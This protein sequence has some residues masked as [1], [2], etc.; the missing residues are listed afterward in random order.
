MSPSEPCEATDD[1]DDEDCGSGDQL[2]SDDDLDDSVDERRRL[3]VVCPKCVLLRNANPERIEYPR[4]RP[5]SSSSAS[6][7]SG[8]ARRRKPICSKWHNLGSWERV[9]TGDYRPTLRGLT[10]DGSCS[11][12]GGTSVPLSAG[13][14][15]LSATGLYFGGNALPDHE[16]PRLVLLLP[17]SE[18]LSTVDWYV[19]SRTRFID[20]FDVHFLCEY[21]GYWHFVS[22]GGVEFRLGGGGHSSAANAGTQASASSS[23]YRGRRPGC[24]GMEHQMPGALLRLAIPMVQCLRG[25]DEHPANVRMLAPVIGDLLD[26][27]DSSGSSASAAGGNHRGDPSAWL[28]KHRD[29]LVSMLTKVCDVNC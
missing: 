5:A 9:V 20:G 7:S 8:G 27:Y 28:V 12:N 1:D 13:S 25:V 4:H 16:H 21:T 29:K 11:A 22:D 24:L 14:A 2:Q 17:P 3:F 6:L 19:F 23:A 15:A 18:R 26:A 10:I